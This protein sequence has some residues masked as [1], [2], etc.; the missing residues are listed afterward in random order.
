MAAWTA[1][2]GATSVPEATADVEGTVT[3]A[4]GTPF[5]ATTV[6]VICPDVGVSGV[7]TTNSTGGFTVS[8]HAY[9]RGGTTTEC[10]LRVP[11]VANPRIVRTVSISFASADPHRVQMIDL[12]E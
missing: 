5:V 1:C 4:A 10:Q 8:L 12:R 6:G 2:G 11:D 3:Q 7:A 9:V